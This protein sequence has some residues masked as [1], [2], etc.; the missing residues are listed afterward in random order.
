M[1]SNAA[2]RRTPNHVG[3]GLLVLWCDASSQPSPRMRR[4]SKSLG[5]LPSLEARRKAPSY[6]RSKLSACMPYGCASMFWAQASGPG[7]AANARTGR[8]PLRSFTLPF[9]WYSSAHSKAV[10][11]SAV[12]WISAPAAR[13][14]RTHSSRPKALAMM[15]AVL[16]SAFACS[17]SAPAMRH[18]LAHAGRPNVHA[19]IRGVAP[20]AFASSKSA[21]WARHTSTHS[22]RPS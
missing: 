8:S 19:R 22:A 15:S 16:P 3:R 1:S 6:S 11:S 5:A 20:S 2:K 17:T 10:C 21:P 7:G 18:S 4:S 14:R 13:H 9:C 12:R